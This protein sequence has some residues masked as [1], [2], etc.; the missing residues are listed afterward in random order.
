MGALDGI[1]VLDV[2]ILVQAPQAASLMADM[3]AD[4]TKIEQPRLGDHA[5][6][7]PLSPDDR[8]AP[9]FAGSN[10]GKR[11]VTIDL[12]VPEGRDVMLKL[13]ETAD[14]M[15]SNFARGTLDRWGLGYD[16]VAAV[17]PSIIYAV[18]TTFGPRGPESDR[19]EAPTWPARQPAG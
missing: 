14:V 15:V 16:D 13:V 18:G 1:R 6:W 5:R 7:I 9:Y 3:G 4:V 12:R 10:R 17:N 19:R 2:G 8:R 11:S